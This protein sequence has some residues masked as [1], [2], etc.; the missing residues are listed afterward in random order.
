MHTALPTLHHESMPARSYTGTEQALRVP[1]TQMS[2]ATMR[3]LQATHTATRL[4]IRFQRS[5]KMKSSRLFLP[6]KLEQPASLSVAQHPHTAS[7][8]ARTSSRRLS[9]AALAL[10]RCLLVASLVPAFLSQHSQQVALRTSTRGSA[11]PVHAHENDVLV[12]NASQT[13]VR[14]ADE[15]SRAMEMSGVSGLN[16]VHPSKSQH[17]SGASASSNIAS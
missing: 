7:L 2:L 16:L 4:L 13:R 15:R 6:Q 5:W 11:V 12:A 9:A 10:Y 3:R 1:E 17:I 14:E 8:R